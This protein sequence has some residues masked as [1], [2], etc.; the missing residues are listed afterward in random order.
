MVFAALVAGLTASLGVAVAGPVD[1]RLAV[2]GEAARVG[3]TDVTGTITPVTADH[4]GDTIDRA[5]AAGHRALLVRLD[6]PGG[7]VDSTRR[8]VQRFLDAPLPVI[9][10]VAPAGADAGSAGTFITYAAHVAAMS[11]ATTIG[12][13]TPIGGQGEDLDAKITENIAAFAEA[14]AGARDRDVDLAVDAVRDGR[15]VTAEVALEEGGIDLIAGSTE[16]L[17]QLIDG[18]EVTVRDET[19]TLATAGAELVDLPVGTARRILG[20]LADP[21]LAFVFLSLG[22]LAIV[23]E[24]AN[25]GVGLGGVVGVTSIILAMFA[26]AVLPV[27]VAGIALLVLAAAMFIVELF[28]PGIGAGAGGGTAAL[29]L[30]GLFLF[31]SDTGLG[32]DLAV[33][34]PTAA[35]VAGLTILLGRAATR[36]RHAPTVS[37]AD[38]LEGRTVEVTGASQGRP[39][40]RLDG[41]WWRLRPADPA[42]A[43][44]DADRVTVVGRDNLDLLV[45]PAD[46]YNEIPHDHP[47]T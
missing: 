45:V 47:T 11:P 5:A 21:N 2:D 15:S 24:I 41:T 13:A 35:I 39:R 28:A 23:Y 44:R 25:P 31:P 29:V 9:V 36:T 26:F 7:L 37:Y 3:V 8:I 33:L 46:R 14:I 6:T 30:G 17:L 27:N 43:L 34:L 20:F 22:T 12:A 4:L 42:D 19:V 10:H 32:V 38:H 18:T 16:E 40:A 1:A